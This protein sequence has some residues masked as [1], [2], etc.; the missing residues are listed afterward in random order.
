MK[1]ALDIF[2]IITVILALVAFFCGW[3]RCNKTMWPDN[4]TAYF[5]YAYFI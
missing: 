1:T 5:Y 4:I 2:S 3:H